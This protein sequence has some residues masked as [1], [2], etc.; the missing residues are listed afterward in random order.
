M[1]DDERYNKLQPM[2]DE[3]V[4]HCQGKLGFTLLVRCFKKTL[5]V[6]E[7]APLASG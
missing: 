6:Y 7:G 3:L 2:A 4:G 5:P 1:I